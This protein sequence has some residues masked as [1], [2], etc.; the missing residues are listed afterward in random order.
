MAP[1]ELV[2][3]ETDVVR[4][5]RM[6]GT[7]LAGGEYGTVDRTREQPI[8]LILPGADDVL[9]SWEERRVLVALVDLDDRGGSTWRSTA[10]VIVRSFR[11]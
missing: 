2:T 9:V 11:S 10:L 4:S 7:V 1:S 5:T 8:L 3:R 6:I